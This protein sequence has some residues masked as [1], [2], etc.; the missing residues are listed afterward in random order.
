MSKKTKLKLIVGII[1]TILVIYYSFKTLG[2]LDL[3]P[4][5][6]ANING[7]LVFVSVALT[8]YSNYVRGLGYTLGID[9]T[10]D[11]LTAL[12]IVGIGHAANMILPLHI[13]DGLRFAFFPDD[14]S[15]LQRTKLVMIPA[16]ADSIAIILISLLA[17]P[18]SGFTDP[19]I[20]H[21][22]WI[23]FF[24]CIA[25]IVLL[26]AGLCFVPRLRRFM[27]RYL[28]INLL[29]MMLWVLFSYILLLVATWAG[30]AAFGYSWHQSLRLSLAVFATTNFVGF[31][32]ASPGAVGLFEYGVIVALVGLG[33]Q[34]NAALSAG[35]L[36]HVIQYA[37]LLPLGFVLFILALRGKY[38]KAV[39]RTLQQK[40]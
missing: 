25:L 16:V 18:F 3:S 20:V 32:P 29:N 26:L 35:L 23:L 28:T 12:Q 22:L 27:H 11:R 8:I 17:V 38:G 33:I 2:G 1:I 7:F 5:F 30:L 19:A 10:I 14:Y 15:A 9:S 31:I 40:L 36:L 4:L 39:K 13:G 6:H 21:I 24:A 37:A 34:Q